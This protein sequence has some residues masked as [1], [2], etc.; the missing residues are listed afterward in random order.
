MAKLKNIK[1]TTLFVSFSLFF[2]LVA[3]IIMPVA[4]VPDETYHFNIS[5]NEFLSNKEMEKNVANTPSKQRL[6]GAED[7]FAIRDTSVAGSADDLFKLSFT[8][9]VEVL[10]QSHFRIKFN[11][12]SLLHLPQALGVL[13]GYLIYPSYGLMFFLGRVFN[14]LFY[15]G[16]IYI[17]IKKAA[18]G[19]LL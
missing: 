18:F 9:K 11:K 12:E 10:E 13:L 4:S 17:A 8:R 16:L 19:K 6:L 3:A 15:I 1:I 14:L 7:L 5:F 2:G